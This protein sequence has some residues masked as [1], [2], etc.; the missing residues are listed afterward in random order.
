LTSFA[1]DL[2]VWGRLDEEEWRSRDKKTARKAIE[3]EEEKEK[4]KNKAV[5]LG[6]D[7]V[8]FTKFR[9]HV[10]DILQ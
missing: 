2:F 7:P 9:L 10:I 5:E 4:K 1:V 3:V 8:L 6:Y